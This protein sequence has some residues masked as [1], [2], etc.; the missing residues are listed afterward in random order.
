MAHVRLRRLIA[1]TLALALALSLTP[2]SVMA[3]TLSAS[4]SETTSSPGNAAQPSE[5]QEVSQPSDS[6]ST[7]AVVDASSSTS[8]A[9]DSSAPLTTN[10]AVGASSVTTLPTLPQKIQQLV[11]LALPA[12]AAI[13]DVFDDGTFN[14]R[15]TTDSDVA[16][17]GF[18]AS[19][20]A[21]Y[22]TLTIPSTVQYMGETFNVTTVATRA[23]ILCNKPI[24]NFVIPS[25]ITRIES[26]S[27]RQ[28]TSVGTFTL[29]EGLQ[30][31]GQASF[32][33]TKFTT[34][35]IP[36][37]VTTYE[38]NVFRY[39]TDSL[40]GTVIFQG[41]LTNSDPSVIEGRAVKFTVRFLDTTGATVQ[42]YVVQSGG[43]LPATLPAAPA[44]GTQTGEWVPEEG[45]TL[46][47]PVTNSFD[48]SPTYT[49][50]PTP[51]G[52]TFEVGPFQY[53]V[54]SDDTVQVGTGTALSGLSSNPMLDTITDLVIP[55]TVTRD[56][57]T[58]Y[59][60]TAIS[61]GAFF[62]LTANLNSI[63]VPSSVTLIDRD[64]FREIKNVGT[65]NLND[66]LQSI[67]QAAFQD[68]VFTTLT[69]PRSVTTYER[70]AF[71][72]KVNIP[73][74][75]LVF[76]GTS[77]SNPVSDNVTYGRTV[78]YTVTFKS[79]SVF[80]MRTVESGQPVVA[81]ATPPYLNTPGSYIGQWVIPDGY[82]LDAVTTSFTV[83]Q[84]VYSITLSGLKS[85]I[86]DANALVEADYASGDWAAIQTEKSRAEAL[87]NMYKARIDGGEVVGIEGVDERG[88]TIVNQLV[89][90]NAE[91][92][93]RFSM[94]NAGERF[95]PAQQYFVISTDAAKYDATTKAPIGAVE[96]GTILSGRLDRLTSV[97]A[98]G[99]RP[100][101]TFPSTTYTEYTSVE[102]I[103][104]KLD[105]GSYVK[106]ADLQDYPVQGYGDLYQVKVVNNSVTNSLLPFDWAKTGEKVA[107]GT[108]LNVKTVN[109]KW[110]VYTQNVN[111]TTV[112]RYLSVD[113]IQLTDPSA[114]TTPP[115]STNPN[116]W[117]PT[118]PQ[119]DPG[120]PTVPGH[121]EYASSGQGGGVQVPTVVGSYP[122]NGATGVGL[123]ERFYLGFTNNAWATPNTHLD[124]N[125]KLITL[126]KA[127][128]TIV[129]ANIIVSPLRELRRYVFIQP[130]G[131]LEYGTNYQLVAEAGIIANN[132]QSTTQT[133]VVSFSTIPNPY[134]ANA[135]SDLVGGPSGNAMVFGSKAEAKQSTGSGTGI[136]SGT[137]SGS[138]TTPAP[139]SGSGSQKSTSGGSTSKTNAKTDATTST[140]KKTDT[141][142]NVATQAEDAKVALNK[143][144]EQAPENT[145]AIPLNDNSS[146]SGEPTG[147]RAPVAPGVLAGVLGAL[148]VIVVVAGR[149]YVIAAKRRREDSE[150]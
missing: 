105:D 90:D 83:N 123:Y 115:G 1:S 27:F 12:G 56:D 85:A 26:H 81:P 49:G 145:T 149:Q 67:G 17:T 138:D 133:F 72:D 69:I 23:F 9:S 113:V 91:E 7:E 36:K 102:P 87:Y 64:A 147:N 94:A 120:D 117:D 121:N 19:A 24:E 30:F 129:P 63:T 74:D 40:G 34:L 140:D 141:K 118:S 122:A 3:E 14:Y 57:G 125:I 142:K 2:A 60:V 51:S 4:S 65:F 101:R 70:N 95:A 52:G 124:D 104:F 79:G 76:L 44:N 48:V 146:K 61:T 31:L 35:T 13:G 98:Q 16:V 107:W 38:T 84:V 127:D 139:T 108:L 130:V 25:S 43:T 21:S 5:T 126:R 62:G 10:E 68:T 71:R 137:G 50:T 22:G 132:G 55:S 45:F 37:S 39:R 6:P 86:D 96:R 106:R 33:D 97:S 20:A 32:Q 114:V 59:R 53:Q 8:Q 119:V 112:Y 103:W 42:S 89:I 28:I 109:D 47:G 78:Y 82:S 88:K 110:V 58:V 135:G 150:Q 134:V 66:G 136:G 111:G 131:Q 77:P 143:T 18:A 15:I 41:K 29:N 144:S 73:G 54:T 80:E 92:A 99:T 11:P 100:F 75:K 46:T 128:G 116:I 148:A 93:L